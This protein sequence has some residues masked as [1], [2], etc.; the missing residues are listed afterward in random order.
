MTISP[1]VEARSAII[2]ALKSSPS[3]TTLIPASRL[4]P[5][6]TPASPEKPFGKYGVEDTEPLRASGWRGG[7]V[8]ASYDV[9]VAKSAAIPDPKTYAEK[10]VAAI[11]DA[12]DALPDCNVDRTVMV[13]SSEADSWRGVVYF[14]VSIVEQL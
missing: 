6:V 7:D 1:T 4:Y 5:T 10:A 11:A 9:V 8:D 2:S 13:Q 14:T 3:V 12:I